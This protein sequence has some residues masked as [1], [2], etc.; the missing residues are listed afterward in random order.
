MTRV[1]NLKIGT[2]SEKNDFFAFVEAESE[3]DVSFTPS[4]V[5]YLSYNLE[6]LLEMNK[7]CKVTSFIGF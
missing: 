2:K 6:K 4:R 5:I 1:Y 7:I 3:C